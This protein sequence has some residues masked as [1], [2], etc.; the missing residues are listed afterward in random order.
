MV[1]D[2]AEERL[3]CIQQGVEDGAEFG[4]CRGGSQ[5]GAVGA[6][7]RGGKRFPGQGV[8]RAERGGVAFGPAVQIAGGCRPGVIGVDLFA[9]AADIVVQ[10]EVRVQQGNLQVFAV[11]PLEDG[12]GSIG[13]VEQGRVCRAAV[14]DLVGDLALVTGREETDVAVS[15]PGQVRCK[16]GGEGGEVRDG[17]VGPAD[18]G[19]LAG[20]GPAGGGVLRAGEEVL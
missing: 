17:Q 8:L 10:L 5:R 11:G 9:G 6:Q 15:L 2:L 12:E 1:D 3:Y 18:G 13:P 19:L 4:R 7:V 16:S 20:Y 14:P